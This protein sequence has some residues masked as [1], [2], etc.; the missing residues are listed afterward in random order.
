MSRISPFA[1]ESKRL[2]TT[3]FGSA[4]SLS[5]VVASFM[6]VLSGVLVN[7]VYEVTTKELAK[8]GLSYHWIFGILLAIF[9]TLLLIMRFFA[10]RALEREELSVEENRPPHAD[11]LVMFLSPLNDNG[12]AETSAYISTALPDTSVQ[13]TINNMPQVPW[14]INFK[15]LQNQLQD[16]EQSRELVVVVQTSAKSLEQWQT[17]SGLV[18]ALFKD[19]VKL[20]LSSAYLNE[21]TAIDSANFEDLAIIFDTVQKIKIKGKAAKKNNEVLIDITSGTKICTIAGAMVALS[22]GQRFQYINNQHGIKSYNVA[23]QP[24]E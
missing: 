7:S 20:M 18:A 2:L 23:Y 12:L 5:I 17:F 4:S 21:D 3:V 15:A 9:I 10:K 1:I 11:V 13:D 16:R 19:K 6:I 14:Q 8:L 22:K 24:V